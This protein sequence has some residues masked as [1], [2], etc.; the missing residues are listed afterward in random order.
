MSAYVFHFGG[1]AR[2]D[3]PRAKD[4]TI[5]GGK[6]ANLAE[7]AGIG[8][9]VPPGF[10]IS[11]E[12][13]AQY[14]T[15]GKQFDADIKAGVAAGLTHIESATG[16]VFGD[17]ANPLLVSVRS[18]ARVSMPGMMDTVLNLGLNDVTVE[19]LA[20]DSG[21]ARF[22][23]D[24]YRRFI[25]MYSD[26]VLGVDHHRFEDALEIAKEDNGY[27]ADVEMSAENWQK[28]VGE[29][30]AIVG[31]TGPPIPAGRAR[32]ALGRDRRG[33]R[34][35]G[36]RARQ[37]LSPLNDIPADWGTAVNVQA[38]VFGNMGDTS[39]TGV[40]F[41]RDPATG[42]KA[43]YGEWLVNAQGEDVVAGIRT[44]NT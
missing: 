17:A 29:Y 8:L 6:G 11:T 13:C 22:A 7:M 18:G 31:G 34:Q 30:K 21:D 16:R 5:T 42:E 25:Q 40:A 44:R 15:A 27:Y 26:V 41:T 2:N 9:P 19:G 35:L 20:A 23:W 14:N 28:L 33:V 39:A 12:V 3:D 24:S 36:K 32:T 43:Y 38:M 4:K 10:T 37:G 1:G